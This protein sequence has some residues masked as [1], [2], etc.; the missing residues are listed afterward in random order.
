MGSS[1]GA[2]SASM[3]CQG[4]GS[5]AEDPWGCKSHLWGHRVSG[6]AG[7]KAR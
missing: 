5:G 6:E 3:D 4:P 7:A 2:V 1:E